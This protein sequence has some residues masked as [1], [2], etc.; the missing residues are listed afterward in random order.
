MTFYKQPRGKFRKPFKSFYKGKK[1]FF[2]HVRSFLISSEYFIY[3]RPSIKFH[4][5]SMS[6]GCWRDEKTE[7]E[8]KNQ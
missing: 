1:R 3:L 2:M 6:S 4:P 8:E 7:F 5:Y